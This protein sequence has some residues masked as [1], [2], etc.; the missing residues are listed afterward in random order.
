MTIRETMVDFCGGTAS[1]IMLMI[2]EGKRLDVYIG[3]VKGEA[4]ITVKKVMTD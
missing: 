4:F 1:E 3:L 2:L